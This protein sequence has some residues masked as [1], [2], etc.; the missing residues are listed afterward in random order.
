[1]PMKTIYLVRHAKASRDEKGIHDWER[2]LTASGIY[3]AQKVAKKLYDKKI[4]PVRMISSHAFRSLNTALVFAINMRYPVSAI[5]IS[6]SL[7]EKKDSDILDMLKQQNDSIASIMLF[8]HNPSISDLCKRL[9][10]KK[11]KELPTSAV[12]CIQFK[13]AKWSGLGK[14]AGKVIFTEAGK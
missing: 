13:T 11:N 14:F 12:T 6:S 2:P 4:L 3:R 9:T 7:Y 10:K 8:G 1:M 5:E